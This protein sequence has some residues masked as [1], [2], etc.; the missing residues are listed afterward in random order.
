MGSG[1]GPSATTAPDVREDARMT[2]SGLFPTSVTTH[3]AASAVRRRGTALVRPP[4]PRLADGIV[5]HIE[6]SPVDVPL[7]R[8]QHAAYVAALAGAGWDV[9]EVPPADEHPDA[10]FVEDTVVVVDDLAVL[11]HP[12]ALQR[13]GEVEGTAKAVEGLGLRTVRITAPGHLDGGDVLQVGTTVYVGRG[14][15]TDAEGIRQ[16]RAHLA[17][18]GRT[19]VPVPLHAVLHLKSAVT[20]LPDGTIVGLPDLVDV[21]PFPTLRTVEEEGGAHVVPITEGTVLMATSAPKTREW[22]LD[23]GFDVVAVDIGEFEKLEGC[24]TCLSVLVPAR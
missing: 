6:R 3:T 13:R 17:P 5:T 16:L 11:T 2:D 22:L 21:A 14:G 15:R 7:A 12:G 20:A 18:L 23:L 24:V 19:V 8:A 9:R 10:V 1:T 4:G